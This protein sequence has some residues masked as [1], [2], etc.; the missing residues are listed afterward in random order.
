MEYRNSGLQKDLTRLSTLLVE[1]KGQQE[2]MEQ[3][4]ILLETDFIRAL[5]VCNTVTEGGSHGLAYSRNRE[6]AA[7]F[8]LA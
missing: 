4:N 8:I 5:K 2:N 3:S 1:K 6:W 7:K